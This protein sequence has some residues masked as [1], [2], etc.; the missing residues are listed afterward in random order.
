MV[1][2]LVCALLCFDVWI[3]FSV[4]VLMSL[5]DMVLEVVLGNK[6]RIFKCY[7]YVKLQI[8]PRI[9]FGLQS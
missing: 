8:L 2:C 3:V 1:V 5:V 9:E 4:V 6:M 7:W